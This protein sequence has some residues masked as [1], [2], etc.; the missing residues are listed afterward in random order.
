MTAI[1]LR[2]ICL[3]TEKAQQLTSQVAIKVQLAI[4][5]HSN[6][7]DEVQHRLYMCKTKKVQLPFSLDSMMVDVV[8]PF[9]SNHVD[10]QWVFHKVILIVQF[11]KPI[12]ELNMILFYFY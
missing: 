4:A 12:L 9:K 2:S 8:Q 11:G 5:A 1:D 7:T 6:L 3:N 10:L